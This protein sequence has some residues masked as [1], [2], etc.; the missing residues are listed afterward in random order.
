M[1]MPANGSDPG[2]ASRR[3]A[4]VRRRHG[5]APSRVAIFMHRRQIMIKNFDYMLGNET[6]EL[7]ARVGPA[8][9]FRALSASLREL[10]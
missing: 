1:V 5:A 2:P 4:R 8:P 10:K 3:H 9:E 6:I 7:C